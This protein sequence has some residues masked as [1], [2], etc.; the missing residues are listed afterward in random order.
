LKKKTGIKQE[1]FLNPK[2]SFNTYKIANDIE[3]NN[4]NNRNLNIPFDQINLLAP[5][6]IVIIY[7]INKI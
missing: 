2:N 1:F 7:L 3:M 5:D 6:S 4:L